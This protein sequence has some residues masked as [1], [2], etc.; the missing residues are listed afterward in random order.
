MGRSP[1]A[2]ECKC[3]VWLLCKACQPLARIRV[4][5]AYWEQLGRDGLVEPM[6]VLL[7][8]TELEIERRHV[9][10][11]LPYKREERKP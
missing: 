9:L 11:G 8:V 5:E 3:D 10:L 2:P 4:D 7:A 1:G 6:K